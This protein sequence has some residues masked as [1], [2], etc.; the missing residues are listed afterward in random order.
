MASLILPKILMAN[1][2][3]N[4]GDEFAEHA[5][6]TGQ[7]AGCSSRGRRAIA[8][9]MLP[10]VLSI[11]V[12]AAFALVGGAIWLWRR[13][14]MR[15]QALL[16]LALAAIALVNVAIWTLPDSEGR[17]PAGQLADRP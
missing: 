15:R 10:A 7:R 13:P 2:P 1:T 9:A 5:L 11:L 6:Q 14:S 3:E 16:M 8:P 12:L 17:S 4:G